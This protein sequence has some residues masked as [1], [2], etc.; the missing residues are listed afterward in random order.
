MAVLIIVLVMVVF[1][2]ISIVCIVYEGK[3][4]KY[5][6][7]KII[8]KALGGLIFFLALYAI[9]GYFFL[10]GFSS[11]GKLNK[12]LDKI[13]EEEYF[14]IVFEGN[15]HNMFYVRQNGRRRSF[16]CVDIM[17][18]NTSNYYRYDENTGLIIKNNK[19]I[20]P[21]GIDI[22][23]ERLKKYSYVKVNDNHN[24]LIV[25]SNNKG[26]SDTLSLNYYHGGIDESNMNICKCYNGD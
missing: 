21:I 22:V 24:K 12:H 10:A 18:T 7:T 13:F 11:T 4:K 2:I 20:F 25:F 19:A 26:E 14:P 16:L 5:S 17:K 3:L 23:Q 1:P 6:Q 9:G 8:L 15:I